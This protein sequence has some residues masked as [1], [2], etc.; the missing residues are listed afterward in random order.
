MRAAASGLALD[1]LGHAALTTLVL[2]VLVLAA[3]CGTRKASPG[4]DASASSITAPAVP[5]AGSPPPPRAGMVY[6]PAGELRA[7]TPKGKTPRIAD[8]EMP[9]VA[10]PMNGFFIDVLSYP[11]EQGAIPTTNVTRDEA[12]RLCEAKGKRLCTELEWER[13]CKGP[14]NATY[15]YGEVYRAAA[16]GTGVTADLSAKRPS[17]E[18]SACKSAFGV[19]DLH[20]SVWEWTQ[21]DWGR[22]SKQ[23]TDGALRGGNAVAG[24]VVDR[25]ANGLARPPT[26]KAAT[27][28]FRCCAGEKNAAVV[29]LPVE[30]GPSL[31]TVRIRPMSEAFGDLPPRAF[32]SEKL[33]ECNYVNALTWRPTP[34]E[35]LSLLVGCTN[36]TPRKC[37]VFVGTEVT[38]KPQ[39]L[40]GVTF[41]GA[42]PEVL[43]TGDKKVLKL[44]AVDWRGAFSHDISYS[45]G[46]VDVGPETRP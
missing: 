30:S 39:R 20:G 10:T 27:I 42:I 22:S 29:T 37:G 15:A 24:E 6:I 13:S 4:D 44:R 14:D 38:G 34:N 23:P 33:V 7:G 46:R 36:A 26:T 25:C 32:D 18:R 12:A 9:G 45:Y 43:P 41:G 2:G 8:E 35:A 31:E 17:G 21:S 28:G 1:L 5:S 40:A 3:A 19:M 16:C 11:N